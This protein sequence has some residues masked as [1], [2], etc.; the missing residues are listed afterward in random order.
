[1]AIPSMQNNTPAAGHISWGAFTIQLYGVAYGVPAASSDQRWVWWEYNNGA[2]MLNAG[3]DVPATLTDDDL[4]LFGNKNG[5]GIRVQ[6]TSFVDGELLVDG[7]ILASAIAAGQISTGHIVSAGIDAGVIKFGTMS[8]ERIEAESITALQLGAGSVTTLAL[9]SEAVTADKIAVGAIT[10]ESV[11]SGDLKATL[12]LLGSLMVGAEEGQHIVMHPQIGFMLVDAAGNPLVHFPLNPSERNRFT[13]DIV[14]NGFTA[15]GAT[16]FRGFDNEISINS[17][18]LLAS[19]L[20]RPSNAPSINTAYRET[21]TS[22]PI[23][24]PYSDPASSNSVWFNNGLYSYSPTTDELLTLTEGGGSGFWAN[25]Q[26]RIQKARL[27]DGAISSTDLKFLTQDG[28]PATAPEVIRYG[29]GEYA[30]IPGT[31][32]ERADMTA[33][34]SFDPTQP[35]ALLTDGTTEAKS[36]GMFGAVYENWVSRPAGQKSVTIQYG[37]LATANPSQKDTRPLLS[38]VTIWHYYLDGRQYNNK[39]E[40]SPDGVTWTTIFDSAINGRYVETAAGKTH[41]FPEQRILYIRD[42]LNGSTANTGNHWLEIQA[43]G[44]PASATRIPY[45]SKDRPVRIGNYYYM[46]YGPH[47]TVGYFGGYYQHRIGKFDLNGNQVEVFDYVPH[48]YETPETLGRNMP[49]AT[50]DGTDLIV[51]QI[52]PSDGHIRFQHFSVAGS[53][54]APY[55]TVIS[56]TPHSDPGDFRPY[57]VLAGSFDL[58]S[59]HYFALHKSGMMWAYDANGVRVVANDWKLG[60]YG[61]GEVVWNGSRFV[62]TDGGYSSTLTKTSRSMS[63]AP[64]RAAFSW[65]DSDPEGETHETDVGPVALSTRQARYGVQISIPVNPPD[66]GDVNSPDSPRLYVKEGDYTGTDELDMQTLVHYQDPVYGSQSWSFSALDYIPEGPP[67]SFVNTFPNG[68]AAQIASSVGN[69]VVK[70]D[71]TGDWP[72]LR[73]Q[74]QQGLDASLSQ[75]NQAIADLDTEVDG[76]LTA[77]EN[78]PDPRQVGEVIMF[79]GTRSQCPPGF[80]IMDGTSFSSSSYPDLATYLGTTVLPD[81]TDRVAKQPS[82]TE[83]GGELTGADTAT[84]SI[85]LA[86]ANMPAHSHS[87]AH[88]HTIRARE[89]GTAGPQAN[90]VMGG[91]GTTTLN[92]GNTAVNSF[93]GRTDIIG[94]TEPFDV[95]V[96]TRQ[97][98]MAMWH[99]I[100]ALKPV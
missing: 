52:R 80:L 17:E 60:T 51:A 20:T 22:I 88:D 30:V 89:G 76:R 90:N 91:G 16:Q 34:N 83:V 27:S 14:T 99:A 92:T 67:P 86:T 24:N 44:Y 38:S 95:T 81:M 29:E 2:P 50:T 41:T 64:I 21:I 26:L 46:V 69:F 65:Y 45:M 10:A 55:K 18:L 12:A 97:K 39:V 79:Y 15:L 36:D 93:S 6:S 3:P 25:K 59:Y 75:T 87:M 5:I 4:V 94:S 48:S 82:A 74:I 19:G 100:K 77:L 11:A 53:L 62:Y 54:T 40:I 68:I 31:A 61:T 78:A 13:G 8:G 63:R 35:W 71:G 32:A 57:G 47:K 84:T 58:G 98:S 28:V 7:S 85:T 66:A 56:T 23:G 1:M 33:P 9:D 96:S 49:Q 70:G 37:N 43:G 42:T 73:T 72:Y